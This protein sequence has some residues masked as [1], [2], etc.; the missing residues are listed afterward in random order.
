MAKERLDVLLVN[1][2]L[3]VSR[4]KAKAVIMSGCV[5]VDG[6]KED[7]A[8]T[9]FPEEATIEVRGHTL[10]YVSRGGLKLEKAIK[11]FDVSVEGKVCTDVGSYTGGFT[12]CMLQNGAV[13]VFAI[14]VGRGQLDWKLRQDERVVCMEKTNIRYVV[15]EDL[16]EPIDFSSIDVSFISLKHIFIPLKDILNE[17]DDIVALIKPQFEAGK[18]EVGKKGIVKDPKTH[19][20]V[21]ENVIAYANECHLSLQ[22]LSFSP[23]TGGEGNIEFLAHFKVGGVNNPIDIENVVNEAHIC[24]K[25]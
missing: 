14:D 11:N 7:K 23:I 13:K 18:D 6:Q 25:G 21:I 2:G 24:F 15:P 17:N 16:G 22:A 10:P 12:D 5:Y 4:E 1:R 19:L 20:K 9:T 3:A 8:G